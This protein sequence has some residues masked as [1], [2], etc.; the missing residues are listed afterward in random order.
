MRGMGSR[1]PLTDAEVKRIR[2]TWENEETSKDA[3]ARHFRISKGRLNEICR[4]IP[5]RGVELKMRRQ[6]TIRS[7][8]GR[9]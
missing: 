1:R 5:R 7:V 2:D 6:P 3:I 4:G 9:G 8:L